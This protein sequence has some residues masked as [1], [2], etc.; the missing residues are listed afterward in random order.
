MS[1]GASEGHKQARSMNLGILGIY[2]G[3][4]GSVKGQNTQKGILSSP[5]GFYLLASDGS[6]ALCFLWAVG[7]ATNG[8]SPSS[9]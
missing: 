3:Y 5:S 9:R 7:V 8:A 4:L 1:C 6:V 2:F